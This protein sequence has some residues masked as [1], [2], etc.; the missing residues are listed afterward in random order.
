MNE[1]APQTNGSPQVEFVA[2]SERRA[3]LHMIGNAH[4][5]PVWLWR[6]QEGFQAAKATFRSA[7][8]RM[9]ESPDFVFTSSSAA[10][11]EWVEHNEPRMFAEIR[12]RVAEGRWRIVGGWWIQPDCNIP[13]GESFVR[14]GLY[15]QRYFREKFGVKTTVGYN[16]D[17]FGHHAML[18]QILK[19]SGLDCYVFMRPEPA[20]KG[21]PG[22]LFWWESDDGSRVLAFRVP[23]EYC[24]WGSDL[25]KYVRRCIAELKPPF[26]ELMCF[27]GVGNHGGGPTRENLESIRRM[28]ADP[29]FP[30]LLFSTPEQFFEQ[31]LAK[32][33]PFPTVHD[34]LQ[35]HAS[36]CYAAHS[37]VKRWNRKA[38]QLLLTAEKFSAIAAHATGQPY[39][40]LGRAWK[41]V[42]FNQFHDILAG[43]SIEEAYED[44]RDLHGEAMAIAGRGLND[45]IQSLAWNI[46]IPYEEGMQPIVIF[47]PHSWPGRV[48]VEVELSG[49]K[50]TDRLLDDD[51]NPVA[52]QLIRPSAVVGGGRR[53]V[54]FLAD[55]PALGWRVYRVVP[56][57]AA[58]GTES[59][60][61]NQEPGGS[62]DRFLALDSRLPMQ[63]TDT[64]LE[65]EY[66]RLAIDPATGC[67]ASLF[68][69]RRSVEV[70][71]GDAARPVVAED[72]SDTWSHGVYHFQS[73]LG[74]FAA[75]SVRLVEHGPVR[76]SIRVESEYGASL[77][78]QVFTLYHDL[79]RVDV[80][81]TVDWREHFKLLKLAFPANLRLFRATYEIPYGTIER[82]A[83]GAEE[84]GQSWVDLSG[85]ARG[86]DVPYGVG[87]L[88]D[89]K[90]SFYVLGRAL[91]MTVLRSPIYAHHHPTLPQ[92]G[93]SYSFI[94]QGIQRFSY[95]I[96]PHAGGWEAAGMARRAAE[97]NQPPVALVETCHPG[98]LPQR[99]SY[100]VVD[101]E[102]IVVSALKQAED[103]DDIVMRCYEAHKVA[104]QAAIV[105]PRWGRIIEAAF[106]PC[107]IKTFRIPRDGAL[108][109]VETN[110]LEER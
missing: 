99:E 1:R 40:D 107:E 88:N 97:L 14:Q 68:D 102:N 78:E 77:L 49:L 80:R 58:N 8:D 41:D 37:G 74:A 110:L 39:P 73:M 35:H 61:E 52:M 106:R 62:T 63:A 10:I 108:P 16:V 15:G 55:L 25:E 92:P 109:I 6:W 91:S 42:L 83:D 87:L 79:D 65:N 34:E 59:R 33:L 51:G 56:G 98:A 11:Y 38:E 46:D 24:T 89:G 81:V 76:A 90:Y 105:L 75:R 43:T 28:Q 3:T 9:A 44:A 84:P 67:I 32:N 29:A 69:K 27:Y 60:A 17:S 70:F 7:L 85:L 23:Y 2:P 54:C 94:D 100:V 5:D 66:L 30:A 50:E 19:G 71:L 18:P 31:V 82:P 48:P 96:V 21:L 20:E 64:T 104:T 13:G 103:G 53:R 4:L 12:A 26:D 93:E 47:N 45:A 57:A 36:G 72:T 86:S 95:A 22:R 101:Q